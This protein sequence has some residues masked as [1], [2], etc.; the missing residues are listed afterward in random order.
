MAI[1]QDQYCEATRNMGTIS[2]AK[3]VVPKRFE[4]LKK[5]EENAIETISLDYYSQLPSY[6]IIVSYN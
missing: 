6:F 5:G 4:W 1:R 3:E 2:K